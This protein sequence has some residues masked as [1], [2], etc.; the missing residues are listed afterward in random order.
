MPRFLAL[1]STARE[2][3]ARAPIA[4]GA[5]I[6]A[7]GGLLLTLTAL[8]VASRGGGDDAP[9]VRVTV[10]VPD[11][12]LMAGA[13]AFVI[14][15]VVMLA[16]ALSRDPVRPPD[17]ELYERYRKLLE[18]PW[19]LQTLFQLLPVLPL[20]A[21]VAILWFGWP[22]FEETFIAW[23]R[24]LLQPPPASETPAP[25][26]PIVSLP[27]LGWLLG[28]L[29]LLAGLATLAVALVLLFAER[30]A[31][32]W[33]RRTRRLATD[34]LRVAVEASLDDLADDA[35]PR[36]AIIR[37]YQRFE[38][39]A[40]RARVPRAPWQTPEEF[41][42]ETLARLALPPDAVERLT[43]LFELARFSHHPLHAQERDLARDALETIRACLAEREAAHAVA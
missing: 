34:P 28:L 20:I 29:A 43:R 26:T 41:M 33:E 36:T 30:L 19:W 12:L 40:S 16:I 27:W 32:W 35:D 8:L 1:P 11:A 5:T 7:G 15:A 10:D 3:S 2:P 13:T 22:L 23:G 42:R 37:C 18:L 38:R 9:T 14:A 24:R 6:V 31:D 4:A 25:E 39:V 17:G 21:V